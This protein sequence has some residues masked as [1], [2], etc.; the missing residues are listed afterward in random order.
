MNIRAAITGASKVAFVT[1][2]AI[3]H[4]D[5]ASSRDR[6]QRI[7]QRRPG[8]LQ[9]HRIPAHR[10]R[11]RRE[12]LPD[13]AG[14]PAGPAQPAPHRDP[15]PGRGPAAP[16]A[17]GRRGQRGPDHRRLIGPPQQQPRG[18]QHMRHPARRAPG[19]ARPHLPALAAR[20]EHLP[21]PGMPP[22]GQPPPAPR[23]AQAAFSQHPLDARRV[24]AY[25]EHRCSLAPAHGPPR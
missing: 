11:H 20:P 4:G 19:P 15:H 21:L 17:L 22:P 18:Q 14:P 16:L 3:S 6:H 12:H 9:R 8:R 1:A 25:R 13:Q 24:V 7:G 10:R 2:A 23:A 5:T